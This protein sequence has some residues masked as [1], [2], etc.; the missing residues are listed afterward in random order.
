MKQINGTI[1]LAFLEEDN[2]QRVIFR[3]VPLCTREGVVFREKNVDFPDQGSL[4]IVPDKREQSTFKERMR[5]MGCLCAIHLCSEGKELAKVRQNRNYD[6][7]QGENN[8]FA[9]YSD[10]ICEFADDGVFEVF[11]E[12]ADTA[13]ALSAKVLLRRGMVLYGPAER[14][15]P[16]GGAGLRPFGNDSYLMQAVETAD[17]R[18]HTFYWNPE[19]TVS[20]RQRRG[21][22]RRAKTH[23][24]DEGGGPATDGA[25]ATEKPLQRVTSTR[26]TAPAQN[27]AEPRAPKPENTADPQRPQQNRRTDRLPAREPATQERPVQKN[28]VAQSLPP[29]T[30]APAKQEL[31]VRADASARASR[32]ESVRPSDTDAALPIGR[33]LDILDGSIPFDEQISKLDQPLSNDANLLTSNDTALLRDGASGTVRFSGTPLV[34]AGV[35]TPQP[36]R[37]GEALHHVVER[38]VRAAQRENGEQ[39][40]DFR[41]VDNPIENLNLALEKAWVAQETRQQALQSLCQNEAFTQAFLRQ[42]HS[43]GRDLR[44]VTAAQEQLED[45]EA[46]RLSLLMQLETA[47]SDHKRAVDAL[48]AELNQ[49]KRDEL[50]KL[51]GMVRSAKAELE[52]LEQLLAERGDEARDLTAACLRDLP[53]EYC[54]T[55][56]DSITLAPTVGVKREPA[57]MIAAV[58]KAMNRQGF[59]CNEDDAT[60][61]MLHFALND[62]FCLCGETLAEAE[63]CA[64]TML[65]ALGL[66]GMTARTSEQTRLQVASLLPANGMRT[67]TVEL[68][69]LGRSAASLFGHKTIRLVEA[70]TS[71]PA[72]MPLPVV[73]TPLFN[74]SLREGR[75]Q[76]PARPVSLDSLAALREEI[77]PL[78]SQG[79]SWFCELEER[80]TAQGSALSGVA[81]QQMRAFVSA[82]ST[83]LRGGFLAAADA[84][85]LGWVIPSVCRREINPEPLRPCIESFPRC[86]SA[87]GVQ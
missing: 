38:Q 22:L 5:A 37:R 1:T 36:I 54:A 46:E 57:E 12:G 41:H 63:L 44:A 74:P 71:I 4:R 47:Q 39:T 82:A 77:R 24:D 10:V 9:I 68:C 49:K 87:L 78:F 8:Q 45:I 13:A 66:L 83:R 35:K 55:V 2:Q 73:Y 7:G 25:A 18:E 19:L 33:R 11:D 21:T 67:P 58:R 6:P 20:W 70:R 50:A 80:L 51:D 53:P 86:L 26:A 85:V 62:G 43:Q 30:E 76:E 61:L 59:A 60:E 34:R 81:T 16:L 52:G 15:V 72:D 32:A 29:R 31:P 3:V 48:C 84:A 42:L 64:R 27:T 69:P 17:G 75:A 14:G 79:E 56:G 65:E 40:G 23:P 28:P